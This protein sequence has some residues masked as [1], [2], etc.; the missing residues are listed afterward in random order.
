MLP[1]IGMSPFFA[2]LTIALLGGLLGGV[3]FVALRYP[4]VFKEKV[5]GKLIALVMLTV[6]LGFTFWSGSYYLWSNVRQFISPEHM[7][8]ATKAFSEDPFAVTYYFFGVFIFFM[9]VAALDWLAGH[10]AR[11]KEKEK[12]EAANKSS[13]HDLK[14]EA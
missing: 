5:S 2:S 11:E 4:V 8:R 12:A 7:E 13:R 10:I 1:V 3:G 9:Y 14:G 6:L